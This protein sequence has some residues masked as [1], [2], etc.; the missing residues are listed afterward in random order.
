VQTL[1]RFT[2]AES[3][4]LLEFLDTHSTRPEFICRVSW[5]PDMLVIW[6]NRALQHYAIPDHNKRRRMHRITIG[7]DTPY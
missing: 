5:R 7:G 2:Q 4:P 1:D 3:A 6:D